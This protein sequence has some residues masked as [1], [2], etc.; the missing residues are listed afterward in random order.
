MLRLGALARVS[1]IA[2][3]HPM[4]FTHWLSAAYHAV[5]GGL[6]I[7]IL[8]PAS[9]SPK[10]MLGVA[11]GAYLPNAVMAVSEFPPQADRPPRLANRAIQGSSPTG[12]LCQDFVCKSP[13]TTPEPLAA[14]L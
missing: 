1:E 10:A 9:S 14:Q 13:V 6:Q 12:F 11:R 3:I 5:R 8:Y 7:A 2:T 4:A